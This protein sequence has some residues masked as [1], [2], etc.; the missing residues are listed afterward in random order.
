VGDHLAPM[1][2][3]F[4][5]K[6]DWFL[7]DED[8]ASKLVG[9]YMEHL[10]AI[11]S[12]TYDYLGDMYIEMQGYFSQNRKGQYL[13]PPVIYDFMVR[14]TLGVV[15]KDKPLNILDP[16]VGTGRFLVSAGKYAPNAVLYGIDIDNRAVR[17]ALAN[18]CIHKLRMRLLCADSLRHATD[19]DTEAGRHNW[20]FCNSWQSHYSELKAIGY[21]FAEK[22]EKRAIPKK[23]NLEEYRKQKAVQMNLFD[24]YVGK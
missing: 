19:F 13:T 11:H 12:D 15:E 22:K 1:I 24:D 7:K 5:D 23:M 21:E 3:Q 14:M 17:T 9:V 2:L 16:C 8:L 4:D 6:M 20:G 18:A 10:E